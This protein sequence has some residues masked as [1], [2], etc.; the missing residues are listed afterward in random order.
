MKINKIIPA[1]IELTS[2]YGFLMLITFQIR[3]F[4]LL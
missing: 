3:F 2:I 4:V 1:R